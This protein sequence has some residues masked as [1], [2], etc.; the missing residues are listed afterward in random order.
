MTLSKEMKTDQFWDVIDT[1]NIASGGDM[2]R[3]CELLKERL[4]ELEPQELIEFGH[5]FDAAESQA[6]TWPLWGAAYVMNGGCSD[7]SFIDFR[8]T[9]ISFGRVAYER[10][11]ADPESLAEIDFA[12]EEDITYQGYQYVVIA[13]AEQ[14]G[15][16]LTHLTN[17]SSNEPS[18]VEWDE[19]SLKELYPKLNAKYSTCSSHVTPI[20]NKPW[21]KLW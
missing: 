21:W 17:I 5:H 2:D 8:A 19:D 12:D 18:G 1:V 6:Y 9:L 15:I 13:V 10:A 20:S 14:R 16:E 3:K 4:L 11:L 7:D